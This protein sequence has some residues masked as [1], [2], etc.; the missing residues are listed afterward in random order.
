MHKKMRNTRQDTTDTEYNPCNNFP[1]DQN[2]IACTFPSIP[3]GICAH[4]RF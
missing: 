2:M 4:M 1:I 3:Y